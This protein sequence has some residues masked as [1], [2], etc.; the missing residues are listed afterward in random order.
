MSDPLL[1]LLRLCLLALI[2]LTFFRV[3]RAVAVELRAERRTAPP[4][5]SR[6]SRPTPRPTAPEAAPPASESG[7]VAG[8]T[9]VKVTDPDGVT[10]EPRDVNEELV[11]GRAESCGLSLA[12]P[13][14]SKFHAQ[15]TRRDD[16]SWL[17]D[18]GSTNGTRVNGRP[19]TQPQLVRPGDQVQLGGHLLELG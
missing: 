1:L 4:S 14:V 8:V 2:Y 12:D 9:L 18:L 3:I 13:L 11:I 19:L 16:G 17:E 7:P 15:L 5:P 6:P 10:S